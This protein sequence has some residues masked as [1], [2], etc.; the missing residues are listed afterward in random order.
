LA[1]HAEL[2][3]T[4]APWLVL[5]GVGLLRTRSL[6]VGALVLPLLFEGAVLVGADPGIAYLCRHFLPVLPGVLVVATIGLRE[7]AA[8]L[9]PGPGFSCAVA[10]AST[11]L[12]A[13]RTSFTSL[14]DEA[15]AYTARQGLRERLALWLDTHLP[16]NSHVVMGDCG[17]VTY[18]SS[19]RFIDAYCLNSL[20]MTSPEIDHSPERFAA[21]VLDSRPE[22]IVIHSTSG[23]ILS[24]QPYLGVW[25]AI[26][27][28]PRFVSSYLLATKYVNDDVACY[29]VF[30]RK[31][32][33]PSA[34]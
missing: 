33:G 8:F 28:E 20:A 6:R 5:A 10:I 11:V 24:P 12:L 21:Y 9:V 25:P 15:K 14:R 34:S 32:S 29:W 30:V 7:L 27:K 31:P 26:A 4:F 22:A 17:L 19:Q 23:L 18:R 1:L 2:W 3:A 16:N 13:P